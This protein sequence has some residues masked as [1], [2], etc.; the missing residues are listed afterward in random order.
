MVVRGTDTLGGHTNWSQVSSVGA[1]TA[2]SSRK[3]IACETAPLSLLL[4]TALGSSSQ[5][6]LAQV[7][8]GSTPVSSQNALTMGETATSRTFPFGHCHCRLRTASPTLCKAR[9]Y[10]SNHSKLSTSPRTSSRVMNCPM[11]KMVGVGGQMSHPCTLRL[12][13]QMARRRLASE[14]AMP[15]AP[16]VNGATHSYQGTLSSDMPWTTN[17]KQRVVHQVGSTVSRVSSSLLMSRQYAACFPGLP[18]ARSSP[19]PAEDPLPLSPHRLTW[20]TGIC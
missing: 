1:C 3:V 19:P 8:A 11:F 6:S 17:C 14:R 4:N 7:G 20:Q 2:M 10:T 18:P 5:Q 15:S 16:D 12:H 13:H 9:E